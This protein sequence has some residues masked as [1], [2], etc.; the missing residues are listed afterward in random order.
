MYG[1]FSLQINP[2]SD[3]Y[4]NMIHELIVIFITITKFITCY[5]KPKFVSDMEAL[6]NFSESRI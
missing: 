4:S 6:Y 2:Q 5:M 1:S 3:E